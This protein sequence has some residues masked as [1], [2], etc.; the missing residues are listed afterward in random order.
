MFRLK[1]WGLTLICIYT[2]TC[3]T[4]DVFYKS[5]LLGT[6]PLL[7]K[8]RIVKGYSSF[9]FSWRWCVWAVL[10]EHPEAQ[11]FSPRLTTSKTSGCSDDFDDFDVLDEGW[12]AF[13]FPSE[14]SETTRPNIF[15][16]C[17]FGL[18]SKSAGLVLL[19]TN[20]VVFNQPHL[21]PKHPSS[22][23]YRTNW[24]SYFVLECY[25][26]PV[27]LGISSKYYFHLDAIKIL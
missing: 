3:S 9:P 11:C 27:Y 15:R 19:Q 20:D 8:Y 4:S 24:L 7:R 26:R 16:K 18:D 1:R 17:H 14:T 10:A 12:H 13:Q 2:S 23:Y 25:F 6:S 22:S 5:V 21:A